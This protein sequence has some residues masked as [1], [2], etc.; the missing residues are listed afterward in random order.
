MT[1]YRRLVPLAPA[2]LGARRG[3]LLSTVV[4]DVDAV[5]DLHLR[6]VEPVAVAAVVSAAC[7]ALAA[8]VLPSAAAVSPSPWSSPAWRRR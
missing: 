1:V 7:T 6:I 3:E 8:F 4:S 5:Q 2:R